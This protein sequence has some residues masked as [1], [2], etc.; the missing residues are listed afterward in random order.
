MHLAGKKGVWLRCQ[1]EHRKYLQK[2][3]L[4]NQNEM[5][6]AQ[7]LNQLQFTF[8]WNVTT[9]FYNNPGLPWLKEMF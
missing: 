7:A 4:L 6:V 2:G 8:T 3:L 5:S 1:T 9:D